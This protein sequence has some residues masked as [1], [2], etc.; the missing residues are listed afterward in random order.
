MFIIATILLIFCNSFI[1]LSLGQ[2]LYEISFLFKTMLLVELRK[3]LI[4]INKENKFIEYGNKA[5]MKYYV[6]AL[7]SGLIAGP[8]FN[9][10]HYLPM[11]ISLIITFICFY[12]SFYLF[13]VTE[14]DNTYKIEKTQILK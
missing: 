5:S 12:L 9:I 3:N 7:I 14:Y 4:Y 1:G 13:D 2:I 11:Y 6:V 10:N 8:I